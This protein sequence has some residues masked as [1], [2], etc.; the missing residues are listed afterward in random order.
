VPVSAQPR[1]SLTFEV[2]R[3]Q[4][5]E[6]QIHLE[7]K[8]ISQSQVEFSLD[9]LLACLELIQGAIPAHQLAELHAHAWRAAG[10]SL[11][12]LSPA[13]NPAPSLP[14]THEIRLEPAGQAMLTRGRAQTIGHQH[15]SSIGECAPVMA[16]ATS[17][18]LEDGIQPQFPP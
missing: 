4:V 16:S 10:V 3:G 6:N 11:S 1:G 9:L 14:V 18:S 15:Q 12:L 7:R 2:G 17:Q 13:W 5:V 8:Q